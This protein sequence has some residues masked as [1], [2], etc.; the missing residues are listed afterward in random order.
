MESRG[1]ATSLLMLAALAMAVGLLLAAARPAYAT[2]F[3]V[4]TTADDDDGACQQPDPNSNPNGDCTLREAINAANDPANP[5]A[6]TINF[7]IPGT[8]VRTI[9]VGST[10]LGALP[11]ITEAVT[12]DGYSQSGASANT[13]A[14]GPINATLLIELNGTSAGQFSSGLKVFKPGGGISDVVI[15]G[16]VINR[17]DF[18]GILMSPIGTGNKI[19][20]NFI[21][22]N[23]AGDTALGNGPAVGS[24]GHG[25]TISGFVVTVGGTSPAARNLISGNN[26]VG[27]SIN[28]TST[29]VQGNYIGTEA[30]G[31][32]AL[33]NSADGVAANY[34]NATIGGGDIGAGNVIAFNGGAGVS[35]ISLDATGNHILNNSIHSNGGLGIDL[36]GNGVT[37]NDRKDRDTGPNNLQNFPV[38]ISA[39]TN[40]TS[41]S[42][43]VTGKLKS[44]PRKTFTIQFFSNPSGNGEGKTFLGQVTKRTDR[45]GKFSFSFTKVLPTGENVVTATATRLDTS[46]T[47]ATPTDT[48]EFSNAVTAI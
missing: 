26:G 14:T 6:D 32:S 43:K 5:G 13:N 42:T 12:I 27:V 18:A 35:A 17:F 11:T 21:G 4:N 48:S 28:N 33:P 7:E 16:L 34:Q 9:N 24:S 40:A 30:D 39:N 23:A 47:P 3:E 20:G 31:T 44:T 46:T 41:G 10:G 36:G 38:L 19:E 22:T 45:Y 2:T 37:P 15:K 1:F 29:K 8:G 25:V